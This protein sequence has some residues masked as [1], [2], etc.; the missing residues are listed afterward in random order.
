[1]MR[2]TNHVLQTGRSRVDVGGCGVVGL[3]IRLGRAAAALCGDSRGNCKCGMGH[4]GRRAC[5][6]LLWHDMRLPFPQIAKLYPR[7]K[8]R[9]VAIG[10]PRTAAAAAAEVDS[11]S[12]YPYATATPVT[13]PRVGRANL[14]VLFDQVLRQAASF[15]TKVCST[16]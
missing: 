3:V 9:R 10:R 15:A 1:M 7:S 11:G 13:N 16:H 12:S 6:L 2:L 14:A 8:P 5:R 4:S